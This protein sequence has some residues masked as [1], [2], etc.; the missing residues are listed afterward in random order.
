MHLCVFN[1]HNNAIKESYHLHYKHEKNKA[2]Q[3]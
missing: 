2:C 1:F 3:V